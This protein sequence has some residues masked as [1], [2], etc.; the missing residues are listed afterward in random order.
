MST[1][2]LVEIPHRTVMSSADNGLGDA[3]DPKAHYC[4]RSSPDRVFLEREGY[5]VV[6]R[7]LGKME[8]AGNSLNIIISKYNYLIISELSCDKL[9]LWSTVLTRIKHEN[10]WYISFE[11]SRI[12]K[13]N[14]FTYLIL[15]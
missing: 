7:V 4:V 2:Q 13:N 3:F 12:V 10:I 5:K 15:I 8:D 6:A 1:E 9:T 11:F 14:S